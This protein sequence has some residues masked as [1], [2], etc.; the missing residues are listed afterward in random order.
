MAVTFRRHTLLPQ[1]DCLYALQPS[2]PHLTHQRCTAA[3]SGMA[4]MPNSARQLRAGW[5]RTGASR[6]PTSSP[7]R[8]GSPQRPRIAICVYQVHQRLAEAG[9]EASVGSVS[10]S[11][12]NALAETINGLYNAEPSIAA[13]PGDP[14]SRGNTRPST[15]STGSTIDYDKL[16]ANYMAGVSRHRQQVLVL[17]KSTV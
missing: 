2:I 3:C 10:D 11:Y 12:D 16:A 7:R 4:I 1:D 8:P 14:S 5:T 15:R 17:I 13:D 9:I 6:S